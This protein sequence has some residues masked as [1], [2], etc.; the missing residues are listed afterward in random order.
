ME[1]SILS[2]K[3]PFVGKLK[4]NLEVTALVGKKKALF[5]KEVGKSGLS[6]KAQNEVENIG[7]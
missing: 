3:R 4:I 6:W 2:W 7:F 5:K 1:R